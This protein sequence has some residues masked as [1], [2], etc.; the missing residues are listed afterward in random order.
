MIKERK[1]YGFLIGY[2]AKTTSEKI[3]TC[4]DSPMNICKMILEFKEVPKIKWIYQK[5]KVL[6]TQML[7]MADIK[8]E[9]LNRIEAGGLNNA[10][11]IFLYNVFKVKLPD[12][13]AESKSCSRVK[14]YKKKSTGKRVKTY[15]RKKK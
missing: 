11:K 4:Q 10:D 7:S 12:H 6:K 3:I 14:G 15:A 5:G 2:I 8:T 13:L 1:D 9:V